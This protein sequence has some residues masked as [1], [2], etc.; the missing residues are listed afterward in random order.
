M[1]LLP[2]FFSHRPR[3][4]RRNIM[5]S[6]IHMASG[7]F[8]RG[9]AFGVE[10]PAL[11]ASDSQRRVHL[12]PTLLVTNDGLPE[13]FGIPV[14]GR[15][16]SKIFEQFAGSALRQIDTFVGV[17]LQVEELVGVG[18]TGNKFVLATPNHQH[19]CSSSLGQVFADAGIRVAAGVTFAQGQ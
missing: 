16:L 4:S 18:D 12:A 2:R 13:R 11:V 8:I 14:V 15:L 19:W 10:I 7:V 9:V 6:Q 3:K 5:P 17:G 1:L